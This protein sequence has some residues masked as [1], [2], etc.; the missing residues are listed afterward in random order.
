M[1]IRT[2]LLSKKTAVRNCERMIFGLPYR[3]L[4]NL[5]MKRKLAAHQSDMLGILQHGGVPLLASGGLDEDLVMS[6]GE[7]DGADDGEDLFV[8]EDSNMSAP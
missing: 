1:E 6:R 3:P 8:D 2:N 7:E 5:Y 4:N